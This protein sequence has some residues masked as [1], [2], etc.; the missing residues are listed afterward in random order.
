MEVTNLTDFRRNMKS[1]FE[2]VFNL[3]VPLFIS[4]PKGEDMVLMSKSDY[5]SMQE[6]FYLLKSPKNADRLLAA[7][8]EDKQGEA[9]VHDLQE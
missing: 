3:R 5:E 2:R 1:Y 6:T 4:R 9:T 8:E 7:I